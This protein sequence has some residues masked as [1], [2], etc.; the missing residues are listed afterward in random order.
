MNERVVCLDSDRAKALLNMLYEKAIVM[1]KDAL[2]FQ[3]DVS[4]IQRELGLPFKRVKEWDWMLISKTG[5]IFLV[6]FLVF[7]IG[8]VLVVVIKNIRF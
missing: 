5:L 1:E 2:K 6:M 7:L 4:D 3:K 8:L